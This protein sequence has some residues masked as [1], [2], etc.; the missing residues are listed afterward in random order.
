MNLQQYSKD[1]LVKI[2]ELLI[3]GQTMEEIEKKIIPNDIKIATEVMHAMFCRTECQF[4]KEEDYT[5][6]EKKFWLTKV[7]SL[8]EDYETTGRHILAALSCIG[9]IEYKIIKESP[10]IRPLIRALIPE[11]SRDI[12]LKGPICAIPPQDTDPSN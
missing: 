8:T 4:D 6:P 5:C 3:A 1:D 11:L 7:M 2:S 12:V 10:E 9:A